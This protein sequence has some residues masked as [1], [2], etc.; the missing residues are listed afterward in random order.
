MLTLYHDNVH[1]TTSFS[2]EI[3]VTY[4]SIW[5]RGSRI[6]SVKLPVV[7]IYSRIPKNV[8]PTCYFWSILSLSYTV[9]NY[10]KIYLYFSIISVKKYTKIF[11]TEHSIKLLALSHRCGPF[12]RGVTGVCIQPS[13]PQWAQAAVTGSIGCRHCLILQ[14]CFARPGPPNFTISKQKLHSPQ[15][16]RWQASHFLHLKNKEKMKNIRCKLIMSIMSDAITLIC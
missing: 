13:K 7:I 4:Y 16:L 3:V 5:I 11:L 12:W 6:V 1:S 2:S 14:V 10:Y 15:S 9:T 8:W